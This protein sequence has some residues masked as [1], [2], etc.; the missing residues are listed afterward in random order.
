MILASHC[1]SLAVIR[2]QGVSSALDITF[3]L[4]DHKDKLF[5]VLQLMGLG[6]ICSIFMLNV[7]NF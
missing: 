3:L 6:V 5:V 1:F 4:R 7:F 2:A